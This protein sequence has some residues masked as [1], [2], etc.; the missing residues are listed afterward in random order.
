MEKLNILELSDLCL[1][2]YPDVEP[3]LMMMIK[4]YYLASLFLSL[5][6]PSIHLRSS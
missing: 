6:H 4:C 1:H 2:G 5:I 3:I